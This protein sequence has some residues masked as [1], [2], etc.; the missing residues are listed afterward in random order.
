M[1]CALLIIDTEFNFFNQ[2]VFY[3]KPPNSEKVIFSF[4]ELFLFFWKEWP[5]C[6]TTTILEVWSKAR[7]NISA[8]H[9]FAWLM[10]SAYFKNS[11]F[12]GWGELGVC[13]HPSFTL[14]NTEVPVSG[15]LE[16]VTS[17]WRKILSGICWVPT[18]TLAQLERWVLAQ[19][20]A[21]SK[22]W[23][24]SVS[25]WRGPWKEPRNPPCSSFFLLL[26]SYASAL[27]WLSHPATHLPHSSPDF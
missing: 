21:G 12:P 13:C 25:G 20:S 3:K 17:S 6:T 7:F 1:P 16:F 11:S 2:N 18:P 24:S 15:G 26:G 27:F 23:V 14:L 10:I 5:W 19:M 4:E 8:L 9:C 22:R